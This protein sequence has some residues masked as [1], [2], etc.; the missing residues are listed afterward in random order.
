MGFEEVYSREVEAYKARTKRSL[1]LYRRAVKV[2]PGGVCHNIR[3][4]EPYPFYS[5]R[6]LG[7]RIWDADGN[8]YVDM[9]M[10]HFSA[11]LGH[12]PREAVE[13]VREAAEGSLHLGTVSELQV[14][15]AELVCRAV[16]CAEEVRFTNTGT[17]AAMYA[18]RLARAYTR[19]ELVVKMEG[20]WHGGS[21]TL[22]KAVSYPFEQPESM[23]L[24]E[25]KLTTIPFNN[26]EEAERKLEEL[27]DR[28]AAIIVEPLLAAGGAI[29]ADREFLKLLKEESEKWGSLLVFDEV[30][31]GFRLA[32]GG[33]QEYYGL[34]PDLAVLG[35]ILGGG[36]PIGAVCG[37]RE[38]MELANPLGKE[39][40]E[41]TWIGGGTF[42][43]NHLTMA[44]GLAVLRK[45][46]SDPGIYRWINSLGEEA[47]AKVDSILEAHGVKARTTG[48]A[49]MMLTHFPKGD[50]EIRSARDC[51]EKADKSLQKLYHLMLI[52]R[53]VFFLPG[54]AGAFSAAHTGEDLEKLL[55]ATEDAARHLKKAARQP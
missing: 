32:P 48:A 6:G 35:K 1:E 52:N 8:E 27:K 7:S 51:H 36:A 15:L 2:M 31:T 42:S 19:R 16:P 10:A 49:S 41:K 22:M 25:Q 47:R 3:F 14:E 21:D 50:Y 4:F 53:G 46:T 40:W 55:Q 45:L 26:L 37:L 5:T 33:G 39:K 11:I 44:A 18:I 38:V 30:I 13:A 28:V 29:P 9:W 24:L 17:E 43:A 34:K 23:G 54:H 20:G 12:A